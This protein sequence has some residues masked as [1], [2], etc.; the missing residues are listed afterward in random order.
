MILSRRVQLLSTT[1]FFPSDINQ[2]TSS[3]ID[4]VSSHNFS[5]ATSSSSTNHDQHRSNAEN[6]DY[7]RAPVLELA[8]AIRP[9]PPVRKLRRFTKIFSDPRANHDHIL[10]NDKDGNV[11]D[12]TV[13]NVNLSEMYVFELSIYIA[14]YNIVNTLFNLPLLYV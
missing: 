10:E 1:F 5:A 11:V 2:S 14:S 9:R 3:S 4:I 6:D 8:R 13:I 7:D 12:I